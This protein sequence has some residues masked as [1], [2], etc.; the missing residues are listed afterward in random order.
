MLV[1][2][3]GRYQ[4]ANYPPP[5]DFQSLHTSDPLEVLTSPS[6]F[7]FH[8]IC[9]RISHIS[10][11]TQE[12]KAEHRAGVALQFRCSHQGLHPEHPGLPTGDSHAQLQEIFHD[13]NYYHCHYQR[14]QNNA[15]FLI[16]S[17]PSDQLQ[18]ELIFLPLHATFFSA[19]KMSALGKCLLWQ[20]SPQ[21][22]YH[23]LPFQLEMADF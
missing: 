3:L 19:A 10:L 23:P 17:E 4:G 21:I 13:N 2:V 20:I 14:G 6:K 7:P 18:L 8:A 5:S 16:F 22:I 11:W 12:G 1:T 9:V 15:F